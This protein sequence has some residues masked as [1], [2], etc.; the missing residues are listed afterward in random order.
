MYGRGYKQNN[1]KIYVVIFHV[2][3]VNIKKV[4]SVL[5]KFHNIHFISENGED[6]GVSKVDMTIKHIL[7]HT[8]GASG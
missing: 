4:K 6:L 5:P 3:Q 1:G 7:T 2:L 8:L